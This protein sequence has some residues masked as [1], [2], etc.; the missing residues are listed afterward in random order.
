MRGS[1]VPWRTQPSAV[2]AILPAAPAGDPLRARGVVLVVTRADRTGGA[3]VHVLHLARG[4]QAR[5]VPV[6][7]V[8]GPPGPFAEALRQAGIPYRSLPQLVRPI[9]PVADLRAL[10]ALRRTLR[11]ANPALVAAH[12]T[13]ATWLARL[14]AATL[15]IPCVITVHG[16]PWATGQPR[17]RASGRKGVGGAGG[18]PP[19]ERAVLALARWG[20]RL[21]ARLAAA[22]A[23][24]AVCH[25]DYQE[26]L[27]HGLL[28]PRR[29]VVIP[30]GV[31]DPA[32]AT[33]A[34]PAPAPPAGSGSVAAAYAG[35]TGV[36]GRGQTAATAPGPVAPP[37]PTRTAAAETGRVAA[38]AAAQAAAAAPGRTGLAAPPWTDPAGPAPATPLRIVMVARFEPP[39]D[40]PTL[41]Q[42]VALLERQGLQAPGRRAGWV[43]ELA[44]DGPLLPA[45][46]QLA[47]SLGIDHRVRFLGAQPEG[48]AVVQGAAVAVL[49]SRREG[50]PLAI[51]E[52]MAAGVP[53]VATAAGGI[54]EAVEPGITG[55]LVPPGDAVATARCLGRLLADPSLRRRMGAAGRARYEARFTVERMV[56]ATLAVYR[57][58][59]GDW[60]PSPAR[61]TMV[62]GGDGAEQPAAASRRSR[63]APA[64]HG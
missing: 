39:K 49:C 3:Q 5:G 19:G 22:A 27:R 17:A 24:I 34:N 35:A 33:P 2:P 32:R 14:A 29:A 64:G 13:K 23:T 54:P 46:R 44:G 61:D 43:V 53:V 40:H 26:G 6:L 42:A 36:A 28:D 30:N 38:A 41:L 4:L 11:Q 48:A 25:H 16:W 37:G 10:L 52:A 15:R 8:T 62:G 45:A 51:L 60:I 12:S 1:L 63:P 50:L 57:Q 20:E 58:V 31:A 47:A 56:A 7:V 21:L 55:F 59:C 9:R 18:L